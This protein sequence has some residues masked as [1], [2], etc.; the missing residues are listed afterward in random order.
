MD[1]YTLDNFGVFCGSL[2]LSNGPMR[3]EDFQ[4]TMLTEHFEGMVET[5]TII[6]KKNGKTTLMAALTLFRMWCQ[7]DAKC[8]IAA[9]SRDQATIAFDW[10]AKMVKD[11]ELEDVYKVQGGYRRM[12]VRGLSRGR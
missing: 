9:S 8:F 11:S 3:L 4:R 5:L 7:P 10:A 12:L 1:S 6:P 2:V